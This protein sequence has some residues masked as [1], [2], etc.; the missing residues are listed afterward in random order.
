MQPCIKI[1]QGCDDFWVYSQESCE[2]MKCSVNLT[3]RREN[4]KSFRSSDVKESVH[5]KLN[6]R[7]VV[8]HPFLHP[9][10][11]EIFALVVHFSCCEQRL[12]VAEIVHSNVHI[13]RLHQPWDGVCCELARE[14]A[15]VLLE[16]SWHGVLIMT[17]LRVLVNVD[18]VGQN[19]HVCHVGHIHWSQ[20]IN[21]LLAISE[22]G[23]LLLLSVADPNKN[24]PVAVDTL[25]V[26]DCIIT[27]VGKLQEVAKNKGIGHAVVVARLHATV[28]VRLPH[29]LRDG[30]LGGKASDRAGKSRERHGNKWV[31]NVWV[32][33]VH[34]GIVCPR[35]RTKIKCSKLNKFTI[36]C[37][38]APCSKHRA[39]HANQL[40]KHVQVLDAPCEL[41][42]GALLNRPRRTQS[43]RQARNLISNIALRCLDLGL[44]FHE[45]GTEDGLGSIQPHLPFQRFLEPLRQLRQVDRLDRFFQKLWDFVIQKLGSER[46]KKNTFRLSHLLRSPPR[47]KNLHLNTIGT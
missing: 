17:W 33:D 15:V 41:A 16:E 42:R 6:E 28:H 25:C 37:C 18:C 27:R 20:H 35:S 34:D 7:L 30:N 4:I 46:A 36:C 11:V 38:V 24:C 1:R 14:V 10:G 9:S 40:R 2:Q 31:A 13:A 8:C 32:V 45:N 5:V 22:R 21:A 19:R 47:V 39:G 12:S 44:L 43:F 3:H 23:E 26:R 29:L